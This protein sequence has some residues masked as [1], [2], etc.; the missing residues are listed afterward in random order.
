MAGIG[1]GDTACNR[2]IELGAALRF[3]VV[4]VKG[5]KLVPNDV[6]LAGIAPRRHAAL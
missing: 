1:V 3:V 5:A 2:R 6:D 4:A